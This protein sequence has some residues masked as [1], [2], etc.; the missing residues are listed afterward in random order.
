MSLLTFETYFQSHQNIEL[1]FSQLQIQD[2]RKF[3]TLSRST[4]AIF[5]NWYIRKLNSNEIIN[6]YL[7]IK[8][9]TQFLWH[10]DKDSWDYRSEVS[11]IWCLDSDLDTVMQNFQNIRHIKVSSVNGKCEDFLLKCIQLNTICPLESFRCSP[12][13]ALKNV[14]GFEHFTALKKLVLNNPN[15]NG[16]PPMAEGL[17]PLTNLT[18]LTEL[19]FMNYSGD[20]EC[21]STLT[22]LQTLNINSSNIENI[23]SLTHLTM[24]KL[25]DI[26]GSKV[27]RLDCL[28]NFELEVLKLNRCSLKSYRWIKDC[29]IKYMDLSG[30]R[31]I[32]E[33]S[34]IFSDEETDIARKFI[35]ET[36][37][38]IIELSEKDPIERRRNQG[39]ITIFR[40]QK[41]VV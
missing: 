5:K 29:K 1:V 38:Q 3:G 4:N 35:S 22:N 23:G 14:E 19:H 11:R 8:E 40:H 24:L 12:G 41:D 36:Q 17:K 37:V 28:K 16:C 33:G 27:D 20:V 30:T 13:A 39:R 9:F 25:L 18:R 10:K 6:N 26:S 34:E 21:L 31:F 2:F 15:Y 32:P 7:K